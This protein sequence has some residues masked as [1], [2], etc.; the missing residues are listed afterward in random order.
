MLRYLSCNT[1]FM[2]SM[3]I[4]AINRDHVCAL[5][6]RN[7]RVFGGE[8]LISYLDL[9]YFFHMATLFSK[10]YDKGIPLSYKFVLV[11][12]LSNIYGL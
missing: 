3:I 10:I 4:S 5:D 8:L 6:K 11:S 2:I 7:L 9:L 12:L 1:E